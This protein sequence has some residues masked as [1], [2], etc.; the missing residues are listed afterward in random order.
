MHCRRKDSQTEQLGSLHLTH[1]GQVEELCSGIVLFKV[2]YKRSRRILYGA[3][4]KIRVRTSYGEFRN[5]IDLQWP[6]P[7]FHY[8]D[9]SQTNINYKHACTQWLGHSSMKADSR[10]YG[11]GMSE[12]IFHSGGRHTFQVRVNAWQIL[13]GHT[14]FLTRTTQNVSAERGA[15]Q[16]K[17]KRSNSQAL[18]GY[19]FE[20][21]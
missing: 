18:L 1:V 17:Q 10:I 19:L 2:K 16:R 11:T 13:Q 3:S 7:P 15:N 6:F 9:Q 4:S 8:R 5:S 12:I 14:V 20:S 21:R